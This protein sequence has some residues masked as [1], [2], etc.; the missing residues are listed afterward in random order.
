MGLLY[1]W[2]REVKSQYQGNSNSNNF[3]SSKEFVHEIAISILIIT[4]ANEIGMTSV[5]AGTLPTVH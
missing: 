4:I 3:P 1:L 2:T 5:I